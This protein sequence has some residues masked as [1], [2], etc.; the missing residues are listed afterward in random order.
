MINMPTRMSAGVQQVTTLASLLLYMTMIPTDCY[1][2]VN[3]HKH[4]DDKIMNG[5][6]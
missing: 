6:L 3:F 4:T 1:T 5:L 2:T